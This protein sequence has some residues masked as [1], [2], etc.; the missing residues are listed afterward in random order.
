M[1]DEK[2]NINPAEINR[3]LNNVIWDYTFN[4]NDLKDLLEGKK[5][6]VGHY[7]KESFF[8]KLLESYTW[9]TLLKIFT[10]QQILHLLTIS[11]I[12]KL[13]KKSL[14]N[15]YEYLQKR[16]QQALSTSD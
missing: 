13:K 8:L 2:L 7:T 4:V 6:N 1:I 12:N 16:L 10:P 3:L 11:N 15:K 5:D 9:F 14:V